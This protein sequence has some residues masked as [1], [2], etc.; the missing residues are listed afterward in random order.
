MSNNDYDGHDII[1]REA[2]MMAG[3][4]KLA[5][6]RVRDVETNKFSPL[7]FHMTYDNTVMAVMSQE[8]AKLFSGFVQTTLAQDNIEVKDAAS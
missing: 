3:P 4:L 2:V 1:R 6:Y 7:Q 5:A 8:A